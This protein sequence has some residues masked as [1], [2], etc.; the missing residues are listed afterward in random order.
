MCDAPP[1]SPSRLL[2][3]V[4]VLPPGTVRGGTST[5]D[6]VSVTHSSPFSLCQANTGNPFLQPLWD[7][8]LSQLLLCPMM[9]VIAVAC[10]TWAAV[11]AQRARCWLWAERIELG[12]SRRSLPS[13][14][15]VPPTLT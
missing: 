6:Q 9:W 13:Y 14:S 7:K 2:L 5:E 10:G 4:P 3:S 15:R 1:N 8:S 12:R 11:T